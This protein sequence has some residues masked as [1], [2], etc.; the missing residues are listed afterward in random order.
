MPIEI[1]GN[2]PLNFNWLWIRPQI[3]KKV[4]AVSFIMYLIVTLEISE[5]LVY[6]S[7]KHCVLVVKEGRR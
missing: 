3:V 1:S 5:V 4:F 2:T 7:L 6:A